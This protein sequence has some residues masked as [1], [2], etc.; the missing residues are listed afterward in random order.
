MEDEKLSFLKYTLKGCRRHIP[1]GYELGI[2]QAH[3]D[4][5]GRGEWGE[6]HIL[7]HSELYVRGKCI[8]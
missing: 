3:L 8:I 6:A 2:L 4:G 1:K 7:A 5:A